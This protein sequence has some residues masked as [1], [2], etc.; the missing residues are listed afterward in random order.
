MFASN[1]EIADYFMD[2]VRI[3][4][5]S[6]NEAK[7]AKK[8]K[9]DLKSLGARVVYDNS[10]T[11][12]NCGNLYAFFPGVI[13][14]SPIL[15]SSHMDTV[16]PGIS[17]QPKLSDGII[18]SRG[19]TILGADD[20]SGIA[21]IVYAIKKLKE[22]QIPH[23]PIEVV[24]TVMEEAGL[25]GAKSFDYSLLKSKFGFILDTQDV[26]TIVN[27]APF[28]NSF[29]IRIFGKEA[30]AGVCPELGTNA[31]KVAACAISKL[32]SGRIDKFTTCNIAK[33]S[34]GDLLNIVPNF[35]EVA[36]EIRSH[37]KKSLQKVTNKIEKICKKEAEKSIGAKVEIE[38]TNEFEG[39]KIDKRAKFVSYAQSAI[40]QSGLECGFEL[41]G[42]GSD[43]NIF[44]GKG[45]KA[46]VLGTGM[47]DAHTLAESI[48]ISD[49]SL[50]SDI[51]FKTICNYSQVKI[52]A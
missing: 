5:E 26:S 50:A 24:L 35:C 48:P 27:G 6:G 40:K 14:K 37:R 4:S 33:I 10:V 1:Q 36:G 25:A 20:K 44:N 28:Y 3:S 39:Y 51:V 8:L 42:G 22:E 43:A 9:K 49:M 38:I 21:E 2:L 12:S 23:P 52:D 13:K 29:K 19:E 47:R 16:K 18:T 46:C 15:F 31:I 7:V 45:I 41:S 34:G 32:P 17:I 30:H 11:S